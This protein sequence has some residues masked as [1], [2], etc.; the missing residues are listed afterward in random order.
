MRDLRELFERFPAHSCRGRMFAGEL[1]KFLFEID[2]LAVKLVVLTIANSGR[3][4]LVIAPIVLLDLAPERL[5]SGTHLVV[6][7]HRLTIQM[8]AAP[9]M[10]RN[11]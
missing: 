11:L 3:R 4:L 1:G 6:F 2:Q 7:C 8:Q 5:D 9:A 10:P